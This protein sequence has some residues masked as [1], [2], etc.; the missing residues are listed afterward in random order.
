MKSPPCL[1]EEPIRWAGLFIGAIGGF[2]KGE[3]KVCEKFLVVVFA[4]NKFRSYLIGSKFI[5]FTIH[6]TI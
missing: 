2:G 5:I 4:I 1:E 6:A 3:A